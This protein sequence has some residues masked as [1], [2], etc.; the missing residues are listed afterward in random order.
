MHFPRTTALSLL[1]CAALLTGCQTPRVQTV[2]SPV[3]TPAI[4]YSW[5]LPTTGPFR[6]PIGATQRTAA[7][8]VTKLQEAL[9]LCNADKSAIAKALE[10]HHEP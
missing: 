7:Q 1:C 6:P 9:D 8:I 4:D 2:L 5:T 10:A 3:P